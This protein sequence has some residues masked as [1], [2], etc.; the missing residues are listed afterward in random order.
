MP[1]VTKAPSITAMPEL[2]GMPKNSV[3]SRLPPSLELFAASGAMTPS[4]RPLPN[5]SR[6]GELCTAW[7]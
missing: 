3:G 5:S 1:S 4:M 7:P 2:P 6:R